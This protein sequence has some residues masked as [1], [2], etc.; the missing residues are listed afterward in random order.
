LAK[1][2]RGLWL[3]YESDAD[4]GS[5]S[6]EVREMYLALLKTTSCT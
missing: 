1:N 6:I 5:I 4:L 3:F 2:R